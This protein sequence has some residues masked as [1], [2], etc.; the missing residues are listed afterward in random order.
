LNER[1]RVRL[2]GASLTECVECQSWIYAP[3][4]EQTAQAAI[5]DS[6]EYFD[7]PYFDLR[8]AI[9][10]ALKSRCRMTFDRIGRCTENRGADDARL[11]LAIIIFFKGW[12]VRSA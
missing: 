3:R 12:L 1:P 7:H 9:T 6:A 5:H 11:R 8:R 2:N 4:P 10:P